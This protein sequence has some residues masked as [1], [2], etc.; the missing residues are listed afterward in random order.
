MEDESLY[1]GALFLGIIMNM[2]KVFSG[3]VTTI[4]NLPLF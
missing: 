3:I 4:E 2:F 1:F